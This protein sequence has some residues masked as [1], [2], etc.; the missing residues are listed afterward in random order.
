MYWVVVA[1]C[2][3]VLAED[4]AFL[5]LIPHSVL[6]CN[7]GLGKNHSSFRPLDPLSLAND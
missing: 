1:S 4:S 6:L 3:W 2:Q 5:P 7:A